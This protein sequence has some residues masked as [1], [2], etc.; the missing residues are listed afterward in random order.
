MA[1]EIRISAE[2]SVS[3]SG[4]QATKSAQAL[5]DQTT[6]GYVSRK[7]SIPTSDTVITLTGVTTPLAIVIENIDATNY[8]KIGPTVAGAIAPMARLMPGGVMV[9]PLEPS[10][11]LRAQANT[12]SVDIAFLIVET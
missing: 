2:L 9:L 1:D 4:L 6:A 7:Q 5:I 11:V 3:K 12:A 8:V 10:V